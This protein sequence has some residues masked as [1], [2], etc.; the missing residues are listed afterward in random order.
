[1]REVLLKMDE[2]AVLVI[3]DIPIDEEILDFGFESHEEIIYESE[4][5]MEVDMDSAL[6]QEEYEQEYIEVEE[7]SVPA[8]MNGNGQAVP[9]RPSGFSFFQSP[10]INGNSHS[11][12]SATQP[13]SFSQDHTIET[14]SKKKQK[15]K[16]RSRAS[17]KFLVCKICGTSNNVYSKACKNCGVNL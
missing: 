13:E 7:E 14:S 10:A 11:T 16:K 9:L 2:R 5:E 4:M 17:R 15:S 6:E 12:E 3:N 8:Q 1:M